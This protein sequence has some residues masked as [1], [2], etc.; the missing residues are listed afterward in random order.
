[1]PK[2]ERSDQINR[3][4]LKGKAVNILYFCVTVNK[5]NEKNKNSNEENGEF[6]GDYFRQRMNPHLVL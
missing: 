6:V 2:W 4:V 1:M 5:S 3:S